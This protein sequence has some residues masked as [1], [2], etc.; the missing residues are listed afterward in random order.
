MQLAVI[1]LNWNGLALLKEFLPSVVEYSNDLYKIY[2]ADNGS[3]DDSID[4]LK[5]NFQE[6]QII[7]LEEN[8]GF[9]H[10]YNK[11]LEKVEEDIYV[12][13]NSDVE[14]SP[15]WLK[16]VVEQFKEN[17]DLAALQPVLLDHRS[18][19]KYEYAG[20]A[21]G[22]IDKNGFP[23]CDGRLFNHI[24]EYNEK[25]KSKEIFW[26]SGAALIIRKADFRMVGGFDG[27]FFAHME[28][29]D[30]CWRLKNI[31]KE[32]HSYPQSIVYHLGGGT[33]G[34]LRPK[35]TYLNFRNGLF[36]LTK[37]YHS[38]SLFLKLVK[39]LLLD[40]VA[41]LKFLFEG[42]PAHFFAV[43][44][45]HLHYYRMLGKMLGKR[46]K[47]KAQGLKPNLK[48]LYNGSVVTDYFIKGKKR[49]R[50]LDPNRFV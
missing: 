44:K 12:I 50:D 23:F 35:K 5:K 22:F 8:N 27:D 2:I 30:L 36:L 26:A 29:I 7:E 20:A 49:F 19:N 43:L 45:A 13:L 14:V 47:L 31:G 38:G 40:G 34:K 4:Y 33:L 21:G 18:R 25:A 48:G 32:I 28:E 1:I 15:D 16:G 3:T 9:A 11:A 37:N 17:K 24:E 39:R 46:K 42:S 41:A 10:G 6:I